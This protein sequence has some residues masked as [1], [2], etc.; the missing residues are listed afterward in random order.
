M[1]VSGQF[2]APA[3]LLPGKELPVPIGQEAAWGCCHK[4]SHSFQW[5]GVGESELTRTNVEYD[6]CIV[7][8]L[9]Q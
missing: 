9:L 7:Q 6:S 2:Y 4:Y 1:E 3:A 8:L 5:S